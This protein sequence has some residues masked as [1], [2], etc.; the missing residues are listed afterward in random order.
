MIT[1]WKLLPVSALRSA[2]ML[3]CR[4]CKHGGAPA[5]AEPC[6]SCGKQ[7]GKWAPPGS[8]ASE[9]AVLAKSIA[10]KIITEFADECDGQDV[11]WVGDVPAIV[12]SV[13]KLLEGAQ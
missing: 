12:A 3:S 10:D 9:D 5:N 2:G 4:D 13:L 8:P 7:Y 1:K 6:T 11:L